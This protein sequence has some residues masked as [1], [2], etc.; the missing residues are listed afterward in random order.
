MSTQKDVKFA[1]KQNIFDVPDELY[2]FHMIQMSCYSA[3]NMN[4]V[5][6]L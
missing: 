6:I 1:L 2:I 5:A 4:M 3:N